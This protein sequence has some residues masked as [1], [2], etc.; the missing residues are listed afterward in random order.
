MVRSIPFWRS[1][2]EVPFLDAA[3]LH[4]SFVSFALRFLA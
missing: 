1:A 3:K 4:I 2:G